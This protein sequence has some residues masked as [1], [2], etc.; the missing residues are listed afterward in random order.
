MVVV[1]KPRAGQALR[2]AGG[3]GTERHTGL[4][5]QRLDAFHHLL[6]IGHIAVI[7][8]L[9]RRAHAEAG[10]A[11]VFRLTCRLQHLLDLHQALGF[12]TGFVAC[13]LR[14][15]FTVFRTSAGFNRQQRTDLH[16]TR[17]KMLA[18]DLLRFE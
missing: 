3:Q 7:G 4:Q 10:G 17:V 14:A 16:L 1:I 8:V 18:V 11:G 15:I 6:Q 13:A 2:L 9:P 5:P 12:K